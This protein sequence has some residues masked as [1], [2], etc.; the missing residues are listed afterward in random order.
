MDAHHLA[1]LYQ[2]VK[3]LPVSEK[4]IRLTGILL[5]LVAV[6]ELINGMFVPIIK[7][8]ANGDTRV[9]CKACGKFLNRGCGVIYHKVR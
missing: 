2:A 4:T 1:E 8:F 7:T 6:V 5:S 9:E 3:L